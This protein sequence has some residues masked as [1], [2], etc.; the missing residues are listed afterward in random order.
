MGAKELLV[1]LFTHPTEVRALIN[2]GI[3]RDARDITK[4]EEFAVTGYDRPTMRQCWAL[5]DATSRSFAAV[6]RELEDE[7]AR[8]VCIF[9]VVLRSLDTIEDDM[10]IPNSVKLPHLRTLYLKLHEPGWTF[11][12]SNEKDKAVLEQFDAIQAE[13]AL[14]D[15]KYQVIIEDICRKMGSGMADFAALATPETPVAEVNSIADYD[16]YCHYVAGL[17]GEGLSGIFS[18]SGKE[19]PWIASQ[20]TLSNSMGL[21]LQK[22]NILRDVKEDVDE[23]RGFWPRGIWSKHGFSSMKELIDPAREKEALFAASEMTLDALR[24]ATDAL[25]YMTLLKCQSVFNFVAIPAVMALATLDVCFMNPQI[26]KRNVK[27]RRGQTVKLILRA[28]NPRD[29]SF[30][31]RDFARSIHS[32]VVPEDPNMLRLSVAC[33][34]I[35]QWTEHHYPSFLEISGSSGS[36]QTVINSTSTDARAALYTQLAKE[37]QDKAAADRR[38]AMMAD[39]RARGIIKEKKEGAEA[40]EEEKRRIAAIE[41]EEGP[42]WLMIIGIIVGIL[43][44]MTGLGALITWVVLT[45]FDDCE[46]ESSV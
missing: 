34:K 37:A 26:L 22:T 32:K 13:F 35:E 8:V 23:G 45:Y 3:W 41:N 46:S 18:S 1:L 36:A 2:Y 40:T 11:N 12:E 7:L 38:E 16:L 42:P 21:L 19:R 27:I 14:L 39:L 20:L 43:A 5:L 28:V 30:M 31:F 29:V 44:L 6:V 15:E 33:A 4:P 9:Y 10:T 25:D 17:V 24:H